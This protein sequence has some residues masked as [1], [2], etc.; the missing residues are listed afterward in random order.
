MTIKK[1]SL[2]I[3]TFTICIVIATTVLVLYLGRRIK[4]VDAVAANRFFSILLVDELRKSSEELTR[5]VRNYTATGNKEAESAYNKVLAVRSGQEPRPANAWVAPGERRVL[6]DLLKE[7]GITDEEFAL[8]E[9]AN[10]LSDALV[11]LEVMAMNAVKGIFQN[12]G[13]GYTIRGEPDRELAMGL[14]FGAEYDGEV[15]KIMAPMNEFEAKVTARTA[16]TMKRAMKVQYNAENISVV[17]LVLVFIFAVFN[18]FFSQVI[19]VNPLQN[20]TETLK[21][22]TVDGKTNLNKRIQIRQKNEIGGLAEFFNRTFE[23]ISSLVGVV[24]ARTESLT[25]FGR[26]LS[27]SS[28]ETA[29]SLNQVSSNISDIK[30]L[31]VRQENG[32]T[33]AELAAEHIKTNSDNLN[34][35]IKEQSE[36]VN[37][38]SAAI[39][40]L[41]A[42]IHSVTQ[43]LIANSKSVEIL[44]DVS[45]KGKA[46]LQDVVK[47]IQEIARESDGLLEINAVME[48]IASQ[49]N[50]LS[51]NAAIEAAHAGE[52]GKGFAVV[53][54]EIRKLAETSGNQSKATSTMLKKIKSSIDIITKSADA[55]L[56][57]FEAIDAGVKTVS[58]HEENIRNAMEE[59]EAGEKQI[60]NSVSR[61]NE[62]T[63][64]VRSS[65]KGMAEA[66]LSLVN[67]TTDLMEISHKTVSALN[68]MAD[69]VSRIDAAVTR[70]DGMATQ[71]EKNIETLEKEME[72]FSS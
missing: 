44:T 1:A 52:S 62:I 33:Q 2:L 38:S 64:S 45:G 69:S 26:T 7:Y 9:R 20:I 6:L 30:N 37:N 49:T 15:R 50:L 34:D 40:E 27:S 36:R 61:L 65:S 67:E 51:M 8:V 46:G 53:A 5:Q 22:V 58:E 43:T 72:R 24:K 41:M 32:A 14:V 66:G 23:N 12:P 56:N 63:M 16:E 31:A 59:Q 4:E 48:N 10:G 39:E 29:K 71:N 70:I 3:N 28:H 25:Q 13:G 18:L 47:D 11:A 55:V 68:D 17:A 42:N 19:I 35:L 60:L 54:G 57:R 21:T